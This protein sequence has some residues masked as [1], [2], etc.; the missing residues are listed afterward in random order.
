[1]QIFAWPLDEN[2]VRALR[3]VPGVKDVEGRVRT[4][5]RLIQPNGDKIRIRFE[6]PDSFDSMRVN[7][8]KPAD[9]LRDFIPPLGRKEVLLDRSASSL[10]YRPGDVVQV[11]LFGDEIRTLVFK[12]YVH[13]VTT[14]PYAMSGSVTGYVTRDT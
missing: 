11:E 9:P 14:F 13:D 2:W 6:S 1:A 5:A 12:G 3:K 4:S 7:M 10:G 8:L